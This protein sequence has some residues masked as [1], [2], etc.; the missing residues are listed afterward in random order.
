MVLVLRP[1]G[2]LCTF[3]NYLQERSISKRKSIFLQIEIDLSKNHP[4]E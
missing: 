1:K 3:E 2:D 4:F